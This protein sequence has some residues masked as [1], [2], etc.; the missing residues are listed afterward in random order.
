MKRFARSLAAELFREFGG[1]LVDY[2]A[3]AEGRVWF[4]GRDC[5][6]FAAALRQIFPGKVRYLTGLNREN[7]AKLQHRGKLVLWLKSCGVRVGDTIVDTGYKGSIFRRTETDS[8]EF[9]NGIHML[10]LTANPHEH[11]GKAISPQ[12]VCHK[13]SPR[14]R[15]L[16][17][18]EHCP[19]REEV[20]WDGKRRVPKVTKR[21]D[22][23]AHEFF[24]EFVKTWVR[25]SEE[26]LA[27]RQRD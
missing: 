25:L 15:N 8:P 5:D 27:G 17:A 21:Q 24:D 6:V 11:T 22:P 12:A 1:E 10:L 9:S 14:R 13:D 2:I 26:F 20:S 16:L 23:R 3:A 19:K 4:L 18:L 7:A